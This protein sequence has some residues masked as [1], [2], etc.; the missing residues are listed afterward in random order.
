MTILSDKLILCISCM[1]LMFYQNPEPNTSQ[2]L[3][4]LVTIIFSC[5]CSCCNLDYFSLQQLSKTTRFFL[6]T[7]WTLFAV[8]SFFYPTFRYFLP[9]LFYELVIYLKP[10]YFL[11]ICFPLVFTFKKES[12]FYFFIII[13]LYLLAWILASKSKKL[14]RLEQEFRFLRD[15]YTE[16][17]LSLQQKN[18]DLIEKQNNEIHIATLKERNRIAREIHDNVG[19]MLSRSILQVGALFVINQQET[20]KAPLY[21]LKETLSSAMTAI[22]ESVH[23]LHEDSIDLKASILELISNLA[24]Y[25]I[26]LEY[27][28]EAFVPIAIKYCFI[29]IVKEALSNITRHSNADTISIILREHPH[30]YQLIITDNGSNIEQKNSGMGISNMKER[31]KNLNGHFS[32]STEHGFQI[33]ISIPHN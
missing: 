21:V 25:Q 30:L 22:R 3:A 33:F 5:A 8:L 6:I 11:A 16:Y 12:H 19:H 1:L 23:N 13:L 20:L 4:F 18:K 14:L 26:S 17:Q 29:S 32:L 7:L 28:M 10:Y 31:V 24:D 27:D 2:V 9:L 15:T